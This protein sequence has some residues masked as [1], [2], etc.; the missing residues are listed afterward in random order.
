M[1]LQGR[2]RA[3]GVPTQSSGDAH[4]TARPRSVSGAGL[5]ARNGFEGTS[6]PGTLAP[7]EPG[8]PVEFGTDVEGRCLDP[9]TDLPLIP[10]PTEAPSLWRRTGQLQDDEDQGVPPSYRTLFGGFR[11]ASRKIPWQVIPHKAS[12]ARHDAGSF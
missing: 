8:V 3:G 5:P 11:P 2:I 12:S 1:S 10:D 4:L 7:P 6:S 9:K